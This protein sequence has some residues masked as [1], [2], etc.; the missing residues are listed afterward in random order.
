MERLEVALGRVLEELRAIPR[1]PVT[2]PVSVEQRLRYLFLS[3]LVIYFAVY[4]L[5]DCRGVSR[6]D[7]LIWMDFQQR[8]EYNS[9]VKWLSTPIRPIY[10]PRKGQN[11]EIQDYFLP[12]SFPPNLREFFTLEGMRHPPRVL[13]DLG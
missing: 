4:G 5:T 1:S 9:T 8:R 11:D 13:K 12:A 10:A 7:E 2:V 3:R 6:A